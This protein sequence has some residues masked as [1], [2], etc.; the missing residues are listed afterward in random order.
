MGAESSLNPNIKGVDEVWLFVAV[1]KTSQPLP[2]INPNTLGVYDG[3]NPYPLDPYFS[4][5]CIF[6]LKTKI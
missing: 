1:F 5:R 2:L 4:I 6:M 3:I